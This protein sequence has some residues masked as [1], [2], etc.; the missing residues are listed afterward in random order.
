MNGYEP[1]QWEELWV[2][3]RRLEFDT[4]PHRLPPR[5]FAKLPGEKRPGWNARFYPTRQ[6]ALQALAE[7]LAR[8]KQ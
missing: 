8:A 4:K 7:A 2:W 5:V 1:I 3:L 6:H